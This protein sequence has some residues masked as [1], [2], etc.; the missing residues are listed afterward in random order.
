[1]KFVNQVKNYKP[2]LYH[3]LALEGPRGSR[4]PTSIEL[5]RPS[6]DSFARSS[7]SLYMEGMRRNICLIIYCSHVFLLH[8]SRSGFEQADDANSSGQQQIPVT[9]NGE[10]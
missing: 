7:F 8:K 4:N 10:E 9:S 3:I 6:V 2:G 1:M 5:M